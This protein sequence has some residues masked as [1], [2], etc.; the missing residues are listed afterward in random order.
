MKYKRILLF[1]LL[2]FL[3]GGYILMAIYYRQGFGMNTWIN[4]IYCTGKTVQEINTELL[5]NTQV[6]SLIITDQDDNRYEIS[7]DS[8]AY[9]MDY[10]EPLMQY[11]IRQNAFLWITRIWKS[12][13]QTLLPVISFDD[14]AFGEL[15]Q[16][17][18]FVT[19]EKSLEKDMIIRLTESGYQLYDGMSRRLN[20]E[21]AYLAVTEALR[22]GSRTLDLAEAGCYED[23]SLSA[24]QVEIIA[25]F[26]KIDEFQDCKIIYDM[27]DTRIPVD[28]GI[29][30]TFIALTR[31]GAIELDEQGDLILD[32]EGIEE[33]ISN[34]AEEYNTYGKERNF[35]S[36]RGDIITLSSGTYGTQLDLEAE[37]AYLTQAFL[38]KK[39]EIHTPIYH[40]EAFV[41]GKNDI[42]TTYI[43][44]DMTD[45]KLYYYE[46]GVC[47][48][49]TDIVTGN[50]GRRMGTPEGVNYVYSKQKNRVL[51]G[52][53]Y[54]APVSF[55]MPVKGNIG[56]HDATWR[57]EFGGEIYKT[58]GSHGCINIPY[59]KMV[60]LYEMVEVG[61]PVI[62]FL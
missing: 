3:F 4:G 14:Q 36:T 51:R 23:L 10:T 35:T 56:I 33:F 47:L 37:I 15:W 50:T 25:L 60:E 40:K 44:I 12:E 13:S 61:T 62:M 2:F 9:K 27:G 41:Q 29:A 11:M 52:P 6:P 55:W 24:G 7:F 30:C 20:L 49:A 1:S 58:N 8:F 46:E 22:H 42:G 31:E 21:A 54:A 5:L 19:K 28:K 59:D 16:T 39:E 34:L 26:Q 32:V 53:G 57:S 38:D 48:L 17:L 43:E 45:Q 18:D